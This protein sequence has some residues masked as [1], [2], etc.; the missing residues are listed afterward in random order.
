[1]SGTGLLQT[2][3]DAVC[4]TARRKGVQGVLVVD[5]TDKRRRLKQRKKLK[6]LFRRVLKMVQ[7]RLEEPGG[8]S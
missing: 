5:M 2:H 6:I 7:S 3:S 4:R 8:T 1:M